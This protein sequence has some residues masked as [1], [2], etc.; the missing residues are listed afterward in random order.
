M[1]SLWSLWP[2]LAAIAIIIGITWYVV[3]RQPTK[4]KRA[5]AKQPGQQKQPVDKIAITTREKIAKAQ[6]MEEVFAIGKEGLNK[7]KRQTKEPKYKK[8]RKK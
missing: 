3:R 8:R 5:S 6:T 1:D 2:V 4:W 7:I